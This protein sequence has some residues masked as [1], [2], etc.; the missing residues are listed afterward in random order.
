MNATFLDMPAIDMSLSDSEISSTFMDQMMNVGFIHIKNVDGFNEEVLLNAI[1]SFHSIPNSE[2]EKLKW[3]NHNPKNPNIYRG[4][5]PFIDN[6]ESHKEL[7]DCGVPYEDTSVQEKSHVLC[8]DTPFPSGNE[9]Y[10]GLKKYYISQFWHRQKLGAR[11]AGLIALGLGKDRQFFEPFFGPASSSSF[12]SIYYKPRS[13]SIVLQDKL[14]KESLKLTTPEHCD[15]G[16]LTILSTFGY[17]GLQVFYEGEFRNVKTEKN[18][19]IVN[20]GDTFSRITNFKLKATKHRVVD[21]GVE[22]Y[23]QPFFYDP[24]LTALIPN[25]I[26][27]VEKATSSIVFGDWL[28]EKIAS[29]YGEWKNFK[30]IVEQEIERRK[31]EN[32]F[33]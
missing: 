29:S 8:E 20:L 7:F 1:K 32:K 3:R 11:L 6:D 2:K 16:F 18:H 9:F 25:N 15:S 19:L 27:D 13:K 12:R 30:D 5:A 23:S 24:K 10:E 33:Q 14:S 4:L 26:I 31:E 21:I 28:V 22:R 17:P